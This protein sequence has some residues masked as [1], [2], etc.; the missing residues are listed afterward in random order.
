VGPTVGLLRRT[1]G[2]GT[3]AIWTEPKHRPGHSRTSWTSSG[4][5][6]AFPR[7]LDRNLAASWRVPTATRSPCCW[8]ADVGTAR[9]LRRVA[10]GNWNRFIRAAWNGPLPAR[11]RSDWR[12]VQRRE[13]ARTRHGRTGYS[14]RTVDPIP[15]S[16][17]VSPRSRSPANDFCAVA[18]ATLYVSMIFRT[19]G[20]RSPGLN[21]PPRMRLSRSSAICTQRGTPSCQ[22]MGGTLRMLRVP[23]NA[24]VPSVL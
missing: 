19:E 17:R 3:L 6:T 4:L 1:C 11:S 14:S 21:S 9:R 20:T 23:G 22:S 2:R 12:T 15:G 13:H 16:V 5:H 10:V 24:G 18:D 7:Y 8:W